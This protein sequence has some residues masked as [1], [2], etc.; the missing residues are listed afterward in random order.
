MTWWQ[1]GIGGLLALAA[2]GRV[3]WKLGQASERLA[4]AMDPTID[5]AGCAR[6]IGRL[7]AEL[8]AE[9][10]KTGVFANCIAWQERRIDQL[11][12]EQA[13]DH[14]DPVAEARQILEGGDGS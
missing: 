11:E 5:H 10:A 13:R 7:S 14:F 9:T 1:W 8:A 6:T 4:A 3:G 2:A 12:H